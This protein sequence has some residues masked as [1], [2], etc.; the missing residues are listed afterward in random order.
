ML[1]NIEQNLQVANAPKR[2]TIVTTIGLKTDPVP[3]QFEGTVNV[4]LNLNEKYDSTN[5]KN[6]LI[7]ATL[8]LKAIVDAPEGL[9]SGGQA[10]GKKGARDHGEAELTAMVKSAERKLFLNISKTNLLAP[11]LPKPF[12]LPETLKTGWY[13]A[14]F[15]EIDAQLK[16]GTQEGSTPQT[17]DDLIRKAIGGN[18]VNK[19]ALVKLFR[20]THIW[21]GIELLPEQD[22]NLRVR[23]ESDKESMKE[24]TEAFFAYMRETAG[25]SW[26][27][28]EKNPRYQGQFEDGIKD[29][30]E[31]NVGSIRGILDADKSTYEFRGFEGET[32][33]NSGVKLLDVKI[34]REANGNALIELTNTAEGNRKLVF[35]KIGAD[36]TFTMDGKK[37]MEGTISESRFTMTITDPEKNETVLT[38]D[39]PLV[40]ATKEDFLIKDGVITF[41]SM[42]SK[43]KLFIDQFGFQAQNEFK[44][45]T[46]TLKAH[47][48]F[49]DTPIFT[50]NIDGQRKEVSSVTVETPATFAPFSRLQQDFSAAFMSAESMEAPA[51]E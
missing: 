32:F 36:F 33:S 24:S 13:G 18:G 28:I 46:V 35:Q 31:K 20:N 49:G 41:P 9:L 3:E 27:Q 14:T 40:K 34:R 38:A 44:D 29:G 50:L 21:N 11:M 47:G 5:L 4:D 15:D 30:I 17:I 1:K 6:V 16:K 2:A 7:E 12:S 39:L 37:Y 51:A 10:T 48:T 19:E 43:L 25:S 26:E 23:V 42:A 8:D 45:N 22:G